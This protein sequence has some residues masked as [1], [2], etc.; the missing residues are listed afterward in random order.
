M[1]E[2]SIALSIVELA[3]KEAHKENA[4]EVKEIELEIG[5]M[6]GIDTEA[7]L[8]SLRIAIKHSLLENAKIKL[9][10]I[11]PIAYCSKCRIEFVP[12]NRFEPCP[13]CHSYGIELR[14]G[15]ELRLKSLLIE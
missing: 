8:F 12:Q 6:A 7:L 11:S 13:F 1:H 3:A 14:Q 2:L 5:E 4:K 10:L 9:H 15:K